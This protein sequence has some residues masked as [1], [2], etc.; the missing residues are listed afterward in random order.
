MLEKTTKIDTYKDIKTNLLLL[1]DIH[2]DKN[3]DYTFFNKILN[4]INIHEKINFICSLGDTLNDGLDI[5]SAKRMCDVYENFSR[6]APLIIISGNHDKVTC[7]GDRWFYIRKPEDMEVYN[8]IISLYQSIPNTVYLSNSGIKIGNI[9]FFGV[10]MDAPYYKNEHENADMINELV[11]DMNVFVNSDRVY[12]INLS[13]S[14][15]NFMENDFISNINF[16]KNF[17]LFLAGHMHNG[18]LPYYLE[19]LVP[20]NYG[21]LGKRNGKTIIFPDLSKGTVKINNQQVGIIANPYCTFSSE[22][23]DKVKYNK[24][25]PK[26]MQTVKIRKLSK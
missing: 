16:F 10:D 5:E 24:L 18:L 6:M 19:K 20:Y 17:D 2:A 21:L 26:V 13:H 8:K 7:K 3:T 4:K 25:Y 14:P 23:V 15:I 22:K 11:K 12:N 1:S 9:N